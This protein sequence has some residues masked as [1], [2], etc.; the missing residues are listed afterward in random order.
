MMSMEIGKWFGAWSNKTPWY[1]TGGKDVLRW[2]SCSVHRGVV[3]WGV[4]RR[5][6]GGWEGALGGCGGVSEGASRRRANG[7][8]QR[9]RD[10]AGFRREELHN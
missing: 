2:S 4:G 7:G 6:N 1:T 8:D 3:G 9:G 5:G 10:A